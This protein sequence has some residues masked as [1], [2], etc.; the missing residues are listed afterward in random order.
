MSRM[1]MLMPDKITPAQAKELA[2]EKFAQGDSSGLDYL[3]PVASKLAPVAAVELLETASFFCGAKVIRQL[4]EL[5]GEFEYANNALVLAIMAGKTDNASVLIQHKANFDSNFKSLAWGKPK[6]TL[7]GDTQDKR[8]KRFVKYLAF[9]GEGYHYRQKD[10]LVYIFKH[11]PIDGIYY[12]TL[13]GKASS[14]TD[15]SGF[16]PAK[17]MKP[18]C[19]G[20]PHLAY[21][22]FEID[23]VMRVIEELSRSKKLKGKQIASYAMAAAHFGHFN[24]ARALAALIKGNFPK[25]SVA[26]RRDPNS[27][28]TTLEKPV[29]LIYPGCTIETVRFVESVT[30]EGEI[31][32]WAPTGWRPA[33]TNHDPDV[34]L[35]LIPHLDSQV[36]GA[37]DLPMFAIEIGSLDTLKLLLSWDGIVTKQRLEK[38]L[39]AAQ[40]QKSVEISAYLLDEMHSRYGAESVDI[41]L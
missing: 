4:Y 28:L 39:Q 29:D 16:I 12:L 30:V 19:T 40:E 18:P 11:Y 32:K 37:V 24:E 27:P 31:E 36:Q 10:S 21:S 2:E 17:G 8:E 5:F 15:A 9:A 38:W 20:E 7:K 26:V 3:V 23:T 13:F 35:E 1:E 25:V 34:A 33:F 41:E 22:D 14:N 6:I